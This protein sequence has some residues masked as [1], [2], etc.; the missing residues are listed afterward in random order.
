[1]SARRWQSTPKTL[2]SHS[3]TN[4]TNTAMNKSDSRKL[5]IQLLL[6][7]CI[8]IVLLFASCKAKK[9]TTTSTLVEVQQYTDTTKLIHIR[10]A[11]LV[12]LETLRAWHQGDTT[13]VV[14]SFKVATR[15]ADTTQ[16][17][18]SQQLAT[19]SAEK[20][21]TISEPPLMVERKKKGVAWLCPIACIVVLIFL[22]VFY[23][24]W[25]CVKK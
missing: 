23:V 6:A 10:L 1:M 12:A 16:Q 13:V 20:T 9:T 2:L 7:L 3:K 22:G 11:E 25:R 8:P 4:Y 18:S 24:F 17:A 15:T 14:R 21:E 19:N 5:S